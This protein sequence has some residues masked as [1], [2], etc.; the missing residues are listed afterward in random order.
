MGLQKEM[1][2]LKETADK[3]KDA[4]ARFSFGFSFWY[5]VRRSW[6]F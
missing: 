3:K 6:I 1:K 2:E 4:Q 5:L